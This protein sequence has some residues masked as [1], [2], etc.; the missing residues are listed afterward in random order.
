V[1]IPAFHKDRRAIT[2]VN[3]GQAPICMT[4]I[5]CMF[6]VTFLPRRL[7]FRQRDVL[8]QSS[9]RTPLLAGAWLLRRYRFANN[10]FPGGDSPTTTRAARGSLGHGDYLFS[11]RVAHWMTPLIDAHRGSC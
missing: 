3:L 2:H 8:S 1:I 4:K 5:T 11:G 7:S 9:G 6:I 10:L